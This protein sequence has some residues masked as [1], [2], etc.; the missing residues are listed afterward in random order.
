MEITQHTI[1]VLATVT[2]EM[3][4][5]F[6]EGSMPMGEDSYVEGPFHVVQ[7]TYTSSMHGIGMMIITKDES[8]ESLLQ[9]EDAD[10]IFQ[11]LFAQFLA[12]SA[13]WRYTYDTNW[14]PEGEAPEQKIFLISEEDLDPDLTN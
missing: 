1:E 14:L 13:A 11:Q 5:R 8:L 4:E 6:P 10:A 9:R 2:P 7:A 12:I 3:E